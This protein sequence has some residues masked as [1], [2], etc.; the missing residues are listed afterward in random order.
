[1]I[2]LKKYFF[3]NYRMKIEKHIAW[4][5]RNISFHRY[6]NKQYKKGFIAGLK[7]ALNILEK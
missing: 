3:S 6:I 2:N 7:E 4:C 1:M 5:E